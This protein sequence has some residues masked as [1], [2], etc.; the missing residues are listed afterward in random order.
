MV[1]PMNFVQEME[2]FFSRYS[3]EER[4]EVESYLPYQEAKKKENVV[5][6]QVIACEILEGVGRTKREARE[7]RESKKAARLFDEF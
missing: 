7:D 2:M 4:Q 1:F 5:E 6:A 3:P